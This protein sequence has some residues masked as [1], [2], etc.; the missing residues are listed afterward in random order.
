M[1]IDDKN[2]NQ[3][4]IQDRV[5]SL[6]RA[7]RQ[8]ILPSAGTNGLTRRDVLVKGSTALGAAAVGSTLPM[9]FPMPAI[10]QKLFRVAMLL[11]SFDQQRWKDADGAFFM[12]RARE[13]GMDALPLQSSN[14]DP[15]LQANQVENLL[16]QQIDGLVLVPVNVDAATAS[17]LRCNE[18]N[19]P[20]VSHNYIVPNAK[21]AGI[22]ARDG[23]E[24]GVKLGDAMLQFAPKGNYI[25]TKGDEATDIARL[26]A[27]GGFKVL[28]PKIDSG[29]IKIVADQYMMAWSGD[30]AR[31]QVEQALT[32]NNNDIAAVFTYCDC[33]AYGVIEALK[34]QGLNGKVPVS[35]E[36]GEPEM[37][38]AI[39]RG[40][41]HVTAWTK[42]DEM[43]TRSAEL[44]FAALSGTPANAPASANNGAGEVPWF[45]IS[46]VN[47]TK[48]GKAP[49]AISV[50]DFADQNPWWVN[51]G[52]LG[53]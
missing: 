16:N 27:E 22:S 21:L 6:L 26:K 30:L 9:A 51:K 50:A 52:D 23:V 33:M 15:V 32:A 43:G 10:A 37:L 46:I 11:P 40:D 45:K 12:K 42:F 41:A 49:H 5:R 1:P 53:L 28:Q 48:D 3:T 38:K 7:A 18:A 20:V 13:L 36:D 35:G 34:A 14:N 19:V 31:K 17:V 44:L 2:Q 24:L 4:T 25:I 39:L 8:T 47:V 29:E